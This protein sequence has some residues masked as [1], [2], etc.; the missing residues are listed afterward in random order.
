[1]KKIFYL[2]LLFTINCNAQFFHSFS[3]A[4]LEID[5]KKYC[6]SAQ[7]T[8]N[9]KRNNASTFVR[10]LKHDG[11]WTNA[12][13]I[14][15]LI[16]T[17][18]TQAQWNLKD[19][20]NLDAAYR[21]TFYNTPTIDSMGVY[22][23]NNT[24]YADSYIIPNSVSTARNFTFGCYTYLEQSADIV[25]IG[26]RSNNTY[27]Y[28]S[29]AGI[30][31]YT[32][33]VANKSVGVT[34]SSQGL[35]LVSDNASAF[36]VY[37]NGVRRSTSVAGTSDISGYKLFIGGLNS[38]GSVVAQAKVKMSF[39]VVYK[40]GL[41][42]TQV[43]NLSDAINNYNTRL[44]R[45][46]YN[47]DGTDFYWTSGN[48]KYKVTRYDKGAVDYSRFPIY[49][50]RGLKKF[51]ASK[52]SL[53]LSTDNG[54]TWTYKLLK[55]SS[56]TVCFAYIF[57]NGNILWCTTGNRVFKSTNNL[58][59]AT[60]IYLKYSSGS[61]YW[62]QARGAYFNPFNQQVVDD[63][64]D[65]LV[66]V[67][68]TNAYPYSPTQ[69]KSAV[70][71]VYSADQ[72]NSLKIAYRFGPSASWGS[73]G[74]STNS[75]TCRHGHGVFFQPK[76]TSWWCMTGDRSAAAGDT[77]QNKEANWMKGKYK[78]SADTLNGH[79]WIWTRMATATT[80]IRVQCTGMWF[81]GD[82]VTYI[83]E[84]VLNTD[85]TSQGLWRCSYANLLNFATHKQIYHLPYTAN[86]HQSGASYHKGNIWIMGYWNFDS[87]MITTDNG[88]TWKQYT[89]PYTL[90]PTLALVRMSN[91]WDTDSNG[92]ILCKPYN[93]QSTGWRWMFN[94]NN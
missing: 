78:A 39:A 12:V 35:I 27:L 85:T 54:S 53:F 4:S 69:N 56:D 15:P 11:L 86:N 59:S 73:P 26:S 29:S 57:R 87:Y 13:G 31:T 71:I 1:M 84:F 82:S 75:I 66:I 46:L 34:G 70:N 22:F 79:P 17:S 10:K 81:D 63:L 60:E 7:I 72:G 55:P 9:Y 45:N 83:A 40:A 24:G 32:A 90:D 50:Q 76:D 42:S 62:Y 92:W 23:G 80:N 67:N 3:Q 37:K 20:R 48:L 38:S 88:K 8:N 21:L 91:F 68:Y 36:D 77:S 94:L 61:N 16:G 52:D 25:P 41:N 89:T 93:E 18:L 30:N 44:H 19:P 28:K 51:G 5:A 49:A 64:H 74:D 14:Y 65:T 47:T 2:L 58:S 43:K 33:V 6:D